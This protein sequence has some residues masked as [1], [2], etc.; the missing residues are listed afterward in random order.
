MSKRWI[1][2]LRRFF[3]LFVT[4]YF[5]GLLRTMSS[6]GHH[7]NLLE[8]TR[9]RNFV[10]V[11]STLRNARDQGFINQSSD[12]DKFFLTLDD[13]SMRISVKNV[14]GFAPRFVVIEGLDGSGKSSLSKSLAESKDLARFSVQYPLSTPPRELHRNS[15]YFSHVTNFL[16][17]SITS[18]RSGSIRQ[19]RPR[20]NESIL[21]G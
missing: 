2:S 7:K 18:Q 1:R 14:C 10:E 8:S 19:T 13:I 3:Y 11:C 4:I 20:R 6:K 15:L 17:D 9:H 21:H 16:F 5:I 12:I